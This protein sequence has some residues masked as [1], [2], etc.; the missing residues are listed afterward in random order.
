MN[1]AASAGAAIVAD[2]NTALDVNA[3]LTLARSLTEVAGGAFVNPGAT[4]TAQAV[5]Q[6]GNQSS[7]TFDVDGGLAVLTGIPWQAGGSVNGGD[8]AV[9]DPVNVSVYSGGTLDAGGRSVAGTTGGYILIGQNTAGQNSDTGV[10]TVQSGG[11]VYATYT[12]VDSD[13]TSAGQLYIDGANTSYT[14]IANTD[15]SN[16]NTR[17]YMIVG[18]NTGSTQPF[19]TASMSVTDG[20]VLTEQNW[21]SIANN[22]NSSGAVTVST[23]AVW[24]IGTAAGQPGFLSVGRGSGANGQ[25][26]VSSGIPFGGSVA[27]GGTVAVG[28]GGTIVSNGA[29]IV[30]QWSVDAGLQGGSG[31][32]TVSGA[33]ALLTGQS[34]FRIGDSGLG[35]LSVS[36]GGSVHVGGALN[37]GLNVGGT[38]TV[39]VNDGMVSIGS[40]SAAAVAIGGSGS[41]VLRVQNGGS[42]IDAGG[43]I[44]GNGTFQSGTLTVTG[45]GSTLVAHGLAVASTETGIMNVQSNAAVTTT[46]LQLGGSPLVPLGGRGTLSVSGTSDVTATAAVAVWSGSTLSV[47]ASSAVDIGTAGT[48]VTGEILVQSGHTLYGDGLI[49]AAVVNQGTIQSLGS[50]APNAFSAGTLDITGSITGTGQLQLA[51]NSIMRLDSALGSGQSVNFGTGSEL[52]LNAPGTSFANPITGLYDGDKIELGGGMNINSVSVVNFNSS[53][54]TGT[55]A[56]GFSGSGGLQGTYNLTNVTF[57]AG[58]GTQF[59][60]GSD[61][62]SGDNYIQVQ[63]TTFDWTGAV[64]GD[65]GTAGNWSGA[66]V[67]NADDSVSFV[68]GINTTITGTGS[69]LSI[70]IGSYDTQGYTNWT[71][72]GATITVVGQTNPPYLPSGAGFYDNTVLNGGSLNIAGTTMIGAPGSDVT[73]TAENGATVST[74]E[75]AIG[76]GNGWGGSLVLTG[77]TTTWIEQA[78]TINGNIGGVL[79]I[80]SVPAFFGDAGSAGSLLV[81][82]GA[83]L[84]TGSAAMLGVSTG[85]VGS[86]TISAGGHWTVGSGGL[87]VGGAGAGTLAVSSGTIADSGAIGIGGNAGGSGTVSVTG[88][89]QLSVNNL[90][91]GILGSGTLMVN[92][93]TITNSDGLAIGAATGGFGTL[94]LTNGTLA[95]TSYANIASGT[96]STGLATVGGGGLLTSSGLN[97]G[98]AGL[99]VLAINGGTVTSAGTLSAGTLT[100]SGVAI[101]FGS[102][103]DGSI[104]VTGGG[105]L[106]AN[107]LSVGNFGAGTL[108]VNAGVV[109]DS[110][111]L[112]IGANSGGFGVMSVAGA[113]VI[114]PP[115]PPTFA[116]GVVSV[117]GNTIIGNVGADGTLTVGNGGT[118]LA[119][120]TFDAIG[121]NTGGNGTLIVNSGGTFEAG[122]TN[123]AVGN[124]AGSSGDLIVN[125]GGTFVSTLA[126]QTNSQVLTIGNGGGTVI[127]SQPPSA[128]SVLVTGAGAL[129]NSNGNP[130]TV[131]GGTGIGD[132]TVA[133]GGS[134]VVGSPNS[135]VSYGLGIANTGGVGSVTVTGSGST[136]TSNGYLLDGRGGTGTVLVENDGSLLVDDSALNGSG[137]GIGAGRSAGPN[138]PTQVGGNGVATVTTGGVLDLNSTVSSI[139][140]G[141]N[142]V[143]GALDVNNDGTVLAGDGLTVGTATFVNGTIYGGTGVVNIASGG[144]VMVTRAPQTTSYL[145]NI[146]SANSDVGGATNAASGIVTVSGAGSLLNTNNNGLAVGIYSD[147]SLIVMQGGTVVSGTTNSSD[148]DALGVGRGGTGNVTIT[149]PGSQLL[150]TG[151]AYFGRAGDGNLIVENHAIMT[152]GTDAT[153]SGSLGIGSSGVNSSGQLFVGGTGT[154]LVNSGGTVSVQTNLDVGQGGVN[155]LLT[156][157]S[158]GT[159]EAGERVLI[160]NDVTAV[161]G[162]SIIST[163]GTTAVTASTVVSG[164]GVVMVGVGGLLMASGGGITGAGTSAILVGSGTGASATLNVSGAGATVSSGGYRTGIGSAGEG[165]VLI[166]QGGTVL[167][168]TPFANDEAIYIGGSAG[169]TGA[170]TVTDPG[171]QLLA[172]GQLSV[173]LNG[174]GSLLIENQGTVTTG[175]NAVDPTE[176]FDVAQFAGGSGNATVTGSKSLLS[177]TGRFVVGDLGYGSMAILA[178]GTVM[179]NPGTA[180]LAAAAIIGNQAGSDGSS[181]TVSGAGSNWQVGGTLDVGNAAAGALTITDGGNV[182]ASQVNAGAQLSGMGNILLAGAGSE[183]QATGLNVGIVGAGIVTLGSLTTIDVVNVATFGAQGLLNLQGGTLD[184]SALTLTTGRNGGTGEIGATLGIVNDATIYAENGTLTLNDPTGNGVLEIDSGG[185]LVING[186]VANTQTV[187]FNGSGTL[188]IGDIRQFDPAEITGFA[189]GDTIVVDGVSSLIQ[190]FN[191]ATDQLVLTDQVGNHYTL[192]FSGALT[193]SDFTSSVIPGTFSAIGGWASDLSGDFDDPTKWIGGAV[194]SGSADAVID[195]A[196]QPQVVHDSGSDTLFSVTQHCRRLHHV[197]WHGDCEHAGRTT[198][199]CRGPAARWC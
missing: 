54:N 85:I 145:V 44:V 14:D 118:I 183:L 93:G 95:N 4:L 173:G 79:S 101:G 10:M 53:T 148:L 140:V 172:T 199:R 157:S 184:A 45:A 89:S 98:S 116:S 192:Q 22:G 193:A 187:V 136:L 158:G 112:T 165:S 16:P 153:G 125:A 35:V 163:A 182:S 75:D 34:D 21:A 176:G 109:T 169:A 99:G 30:D 64:S 68:S 195:F 97:V 196:D 28:S 117:T 33:G 175:N 130:I 110:D 138:S 143:N 58:S 167:T 69:A 129:L 56:I 27:A 1:S 23:G 6:V 131:G 134:V 127:S 29:T 36:N 90:S 73:V 38:G 62:L 105:Q 164:N 120:G 76:N 71:F 188:T 86:A 102:G 197:R 49:A 159:V 37:L 191:S 84:T 55:I 50:T 149:D 61:F 162:N 72:S 155:G 135:S 190:S 32:V 41:G 60:W 82:N 26:L 94:N 156:V 174:D 63:P 124:F 154:A 170:L 96:D 12:E 65:Y 3:S 198:R 150:L 133:Q 57:A 51:A 7:I 168:G 11:V 2:G 181:D 47:D 31:T 160:G 151:G 52:I 8:L 144:T 171:S 147:G 119:N 88:G 122:A 67:P 128:G 15:T 78:V 17:G 46:S 43:L 189:A 66:V 166:S 48:F 113:T 132:L 42:V 9:V 39:T 161:A 70:N 114:N 137:I 115:S 152:L 178:G 146:G 91:V 77:P 141:G 186:A 100:G 20:A 111:G 74:I 24:N 18:S 59:A 25:L 194:P 107:G 80:G 19:G 40:T 92:G 81:T 104:S 139:T 108:A 103:S 13:Q 121:N 179:T 142:G 177:N 180:S 123:V 126:P 87:Q 5:Q 83:S 106:N 185:D